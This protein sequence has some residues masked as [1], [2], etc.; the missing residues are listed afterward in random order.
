MHT[1][2]IDALA[3]TRRANG[4][5]AIGCRHGYDSESNHE[6]AQNQMFFAWVI[7][8]FQSK[9]GKAFWVMIQFDLNPREAAR[10]KS[11]YESIHGESAWVMSSVRHGLGRPMGHGLGR[12]WVRAGLKFLRN[13]WALDGPGLEFWNFM[14]NAAGEIIYIKSTFIL[15]CNTGE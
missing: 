6:S 3:I 14:N 15:L 2:Y 13:E 4:R 8:R 5:M 1:L 11:R 12:Q 7:S 10:A 9:I